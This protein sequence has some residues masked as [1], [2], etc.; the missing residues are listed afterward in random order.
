LNNSIHYTFIFNKGS[1]L[2]ENIDNI[3]NI[4]QFDD[5]KLNSLNLITKEF[6]GFY[7]NRSCYCFEITENIFDNPNYS[8]VKVRNLFEQIPEELFWLAGKA[9]HIIHWSQNNKFCG[10]CGKP[11]EN[12]A[13]ERAKKCTSCDNLVYPRISPAIIVAITKG[14][15]ILLARGNRPEFKFHSVLAGFVE[16]GESLED[17]VKR[18]VMEEVGIKVKNIKYFSSQQW[19]FPD[20]LMIGFTAEH[21]KGEINI[22]NKEIAEANWFKKENMPDIPGNLSISRKLINWFINNS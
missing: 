9:A 5:E 14:K 12:H 18:E 21:D 2:V 10:K 16:P 15:E 4:P 1:I 6:L 11:M 3:I 7:E 20:S 13:E 22:D 8:F 17:C 19:P